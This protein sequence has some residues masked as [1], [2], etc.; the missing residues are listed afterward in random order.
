MLVPIASH[1]DCF[2]SDLEKYRGQIRV[3]LN[4]FGVVKADLIQPP[5]PESPLHSAQRTT[6]I[7]ETLL[8][9]M[10]T[11]FLRS[12]V[13]LRKRRHNLGL[14]GLKLSQR[15]RKW[16]C[17]RVSRFVP[18]GAQTDHLEDIVY[19]FDSPEAMRLGSGMTAEEVQYYAYLFIGEVVW[20]VERLMV[21]F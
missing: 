4:M 14:E 19:R 9:Q 1:L 6:T 16:V 7:L 11:S 5:E 21:P 18:F 8:E 10:V 17:G 15:L 20:V 2:G 12:C 3:R 13:L